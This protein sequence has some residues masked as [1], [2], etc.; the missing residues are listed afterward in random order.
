MCKEN[1]PMLY[2]LIFLRLRPQL[3]MPLIVT[4][5][6]HSVIYIYIQHSPSSPTCYLTRA[7][8]SRGVW[9]GSGLGSGFWVPGRAGSESGLGSVLDLG[10]ESPVPNQGRIPGLGSRV[11]FRVRSR[12]NSQIG[13]GR[14]IS[15]QGQGWEFGP[16]LVSGLSPE[17]R[18]SLESIMGWVRVP[19]WGRKS[20]LVSGP[21]PGSRS[22]KYS[23]YFM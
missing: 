19:S 5:I 9:V 18:S 7:I 8:G 23:S 22:K 16:R 2:C 11:G 13:I 6:N 4:N 14:Q 17:S 20:G 3:D 15:K 12:V 21:C 10:S 1:S